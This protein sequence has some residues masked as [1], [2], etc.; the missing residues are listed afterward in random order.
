MKI[1]S[2]IAIYFVIWWTMLF[3]VL[4]FGVRNANEAG[5]EVKPGNDRGAPVALYWGKK[6]LATSLLALVVFGVVYAQMV[7][8]VFGGG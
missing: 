4:P 1:G 6:L 3:V 8:H 5:E 7:F 2:M